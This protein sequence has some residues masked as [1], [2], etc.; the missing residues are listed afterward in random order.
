[1]R[2]VNTFFPFF[3]NKHIDEVPSNEKKFD[4][5]A[6]KNCADI[7][8]RAKLVT[9]FNSSSFRSGLLKEPSFTFSIF[10]LKLLEILVSQFGKLVFFSQHLSFRFDCG[11]ELMK[12]PV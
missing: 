11:V 12:V 2:T 6:L 7:F 1:M 8:L 9:T 4:N 5:Y 3:L 10:F